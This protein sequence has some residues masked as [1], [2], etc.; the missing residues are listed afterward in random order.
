MNS[1]VTKKERRFSQGVD[2]TGKRVVLYD[3]EDIAGARVAGKLVA[4]VL[5]FITPH[6]VPGIPTLDLDILIEKF[7]TDHGAIAATKGYRGYPASSCISVNNVVNH[8]IPSA[9]KILK[10][11]DII[12]IDI[13][14]IVNQWYGDSGRM[15][16]VGEVKD[17][18]IAAQRLV[19]AAYEAMIAGIDAVRPGIALSNVGCAIQDVTDKYHYSCVTDY[20]GHGIGL[21]FHDAPFVRQYRT[22]RDLGLILEPGMMFT[23]EPMINIGKSGVR[24]LPDGWTAVT[25]DH[26]LSAQ[27]EH[28]LVVTEAGH[29]I[30]TLSPKGYTLP[31]YR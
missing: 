1:H 30:L 9:T 8:G 18:P 3:E 14:V 23:I 6:V 28:T 12:N 29:E 10:H 20:G 13:T 31:P 16:Y 21:V 22:K 4:E 2:V 7:I 27:F 25:K 17:I 26:S 11:G 5:D 24:V 19:K 15:F